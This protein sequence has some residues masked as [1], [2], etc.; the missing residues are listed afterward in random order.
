M[1]TLRTVSAVL[2][3]VLAFGSPAFA[4]YRVN[5]ASGGSGW[6]GSPPLPEAAQGQGLVYSQG[7]QANISPSH[8]GGLVVACE[9]LRGTAAAVDIFGPGGPGCPHGQ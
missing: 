7:A 4:H 1:R 9:A 3:L 2:V 5:A 6:V 8:F